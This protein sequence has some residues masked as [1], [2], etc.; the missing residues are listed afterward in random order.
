MLKLAWNAARGLWPEVKLLPLRAAVALGSSGL[1]QPVRPAQLWK[2]YAIVLPVGFAATWA[3]PQLIWVMSP[4]ID[5][6]AVRPAAGP[7]R[8]GDFVMF[9]LSHPLAGPKPVNVTKRALCLPGEH[10]V[11]IEKPSMMPVAPQGERDGYYYCNG[12]LLNVSKA[13]GRNGQKLQ[14]WHPVQATIPQG[15]V[16]VGSGHPDGFDSRYYGPVAIGRLTRMEKI[17]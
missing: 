16:F 17:L 5:A 15:F 14:H 3:I 11:M 13:N 7:I 1:G 9:L 6:V 12:H 10:I 2:A 4:S 8:K